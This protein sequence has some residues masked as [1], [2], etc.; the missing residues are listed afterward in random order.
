MWCHGCISACS[1]YADMLAYIHTCARIVCMHVH[2]RNWQLGKHHQNHFW[3]R[4]EQQQTG[5]LSEVHTGLC[6]STLGQEASGSSMNSSEW[7][8][9]KSRANTRQA[10]WESSMV[11]KLGKMMTASSYCKQESLAAFQVLRRCGKVAS[12]LTLQMEGLS[13]DTEQILI[14]SWSCINMQVTQVTSRSEIHSVSC[15]V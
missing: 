15:I 12:K 3:H 7:S 2:T 8:T 6:I 9:E 13:A 4:H 1:A 10:S 11:S 14:W 5:S